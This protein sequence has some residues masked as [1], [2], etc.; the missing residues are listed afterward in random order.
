MCV[1]NLITLAK[2]PRRIVTIR[3]KAQLQSTP[4]Q[5]RTD[6]SHKNDAR[7][8]GRGAVPTSAAQH[9]RTNHHHYLQEQQSR[10]SK[11]TGNFLLAIHTQNTYK[12]DESSTSTVYVLLIY[13]LDDVFLP[14][15]TGL[16]NS[17]LLVGIVP[18][19]SDQ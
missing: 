4:H 8:G 5:P 12:P 11:A 10:G 2:R 7:Q 15:Q 17:P 3:P 16:S 14:P 19:G 18:V 6:M 1:A 9:V 13:R